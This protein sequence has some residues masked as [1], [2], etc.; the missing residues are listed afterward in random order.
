MNK[1]LTEIEIIASKRFFGSQEARRFLDETRPLI[2][3]VYK[4]LR[5]NVKSRYG[6]IVVDLW[7][8]SV[9]DEY[10]LPSHQYDTM[11]GVCVINIAYDLSAYTSEN[12]K[13]IKNEIV[14]NILKDAFQSSPNE[15]GLERE[16]IINILTSVYDALL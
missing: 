11:S 10:E 13:N 12:N 6:K 8:Q 4:K 7:P 1:W 2:D 3:G 5:R 9:I 14:Y 16:L 15:I